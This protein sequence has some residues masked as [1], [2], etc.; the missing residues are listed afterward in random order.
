MHPARKELMERPIHI[1]VDGA[2][3]CGGFS[4]L[5][6]IDMFESECEDCAKCVN[7]LDNGM[8]CVSS[9][10][11]PSSSSSFSEYLDP[12]PSQTSAALR[13]WIIKNTDQIIESFAVVKTSIII[14]HRKG[15]RG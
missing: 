9:V 5:L 8:Q 2:S 10:S 3:M 13:R 15:R 1:E 12:S 11:I 4:G 6:V 14:V 7:E